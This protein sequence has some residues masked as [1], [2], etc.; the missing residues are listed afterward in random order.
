MIDGYS[1]EPRTSTNV[2]NLSDARDRVKSDE[3]INKHV[4]EPVDESTDESIDD[5]YD[6][7]D[8]EH[9]KFLE[10][11]ERYI[12]NILF[13]ATK[14]IERSIKRLENGQAIIMLLMVLQSVT[15][16]VVW[17]TNI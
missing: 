6:Y 15:L 7:M 4:D 11:E 2:I 9:I 14:P 3:L 13:G 12:N 16:L 1:E 10:E 17:L 8:Y 5:D